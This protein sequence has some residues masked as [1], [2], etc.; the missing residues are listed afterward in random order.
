[1]ISPVLATVLAS[2]RAPLNRR[3]GE[4]RRATPGFD[5]AAL[6]AFF[7]DA[8]DP[9][10]Q[11]AALVDEA[12]LPV[13][14]QAAVET[15]LQLGVH[16]RA[17]AARTAQVR[18]TWRA[19]A[20][21]CAA[22]IAAAPAQVLGMLANAVL[23]VTQ[24]G[25]RGGQ[26]RDELAALAGRATDTR[27]L[28]V[29]GQLLAWR[30]GLAHFRRGALAAAA[31]PPPA[32]A[33]AAL[34]LPESLRWEDAVAALAADPWWGPDGRADAGIE[35]GAFAGLGG[36]FMAPPQVRP[37]HDGFLVDG[38][39]RHHLLVADRH[40]AVLHAASAAEYEAAPAQCGHPA[41]RIE[42]DTLHLGARRVA[43][44]LPAA[45]L[46]V[47]CNADTVAV[48]SPFTHTIR[49]LPLP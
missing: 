1:M 35:T 16:D 29:L 4:V 42:G 30:A 6:A 39:A 46:R 34:K 27:E 20:G 9:V 17:L 21:P 23:H 10:V 48:T 40:G 12:R 32:L 5:D 2:A 7:G 13:V 8:I 19:L 37:A 15:A 22:L 26:W 11:A 47:V 25:G 14:V 45:G 31:G 33:L 43:L 28:A 44:D 18:D 38:G 3:I 24:Q 41:V 49:L 36:A